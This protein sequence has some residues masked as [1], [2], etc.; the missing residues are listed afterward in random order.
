MITAVTTLPV[1]TASTY[2]EKGM[3]ITGNIKIAIVVQIKCRKEVPE[4]NTITMITCP[5]LTVKLNAPITVHALDLNTSIRDM[6]ANARSGTTLQFGRKPK[7]LI[8]ILFMRGVTGKSHHILTSFK[9]VETRARGAR[10]GS[11]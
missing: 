8:I 7:V 11:V 10:G 6:P 9:H 3:W 4:T 2:L 5:L 1:G